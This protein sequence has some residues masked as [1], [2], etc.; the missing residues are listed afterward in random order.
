M[1]IRCL[2][3]WW[4]SNLISVIIT[5]ELLKRTEARVRWDGRRFFVFS[6]N[7]MWGSHQSLKTIHVEYGRPSICIRPLPHLHTQNS[8]KVQFSSVQFSSS[9]L[10]DSLWPHGL[11]HARPPC[12]TPTP[13]VYPNSCP[14]S[15]WCHP[16]ISSS[17]V[18]F[19]SHLQ[20]LPASG[21]FQTSQLFQSGGQSTFYV[22]TCSEWAGTSILTNSGDGQCF[23]F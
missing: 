22:P 4:F 18:P 9:I 6:Q 23:S 16:T 3:L 10:S 15:R 14:L 13:G 11:Q 17:V 5:C 1:S 12:P 8:W 20:S 19:F 21:S 2:V 7:S